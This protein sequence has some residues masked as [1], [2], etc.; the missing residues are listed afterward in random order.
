[1]T[2]R[3]AASKI[4]TIV[5]DLQQAAME[6]GAPQRR[7]LVGGARISLQVQASVITLGIWRRGTKVGEGELTVFQRDCGVPA[8]AQRWPTSGQMSRRQN[9]ATWWGVG[10]RWSV[11]VESEGT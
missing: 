7:D 3:A 5:A 6:S 4:T 8:G 11:E 9:G 10:F 1:M 2:T